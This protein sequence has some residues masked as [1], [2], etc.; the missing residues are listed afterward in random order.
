LRAA[1][2]TTIGT[3]N[4]VKMR[5]KCLRKGIQVGGIEI[6]KISIPAEADQKQ[7]QVMLIESNYSL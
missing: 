7:Q 5:A 6:P 3:L 2:F 4:Q 1:V